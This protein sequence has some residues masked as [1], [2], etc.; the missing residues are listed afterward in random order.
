MLL[1]SSFGEADEDSSCRTGRRHRLR[2]DRRLALQV[3]DSSYEPLAQ[4]E[5]PVV[6]L[7]VADL[8]CPLLGFY[9]LH[10]GRT[11]FLVDGDLEHRHGS[12]SR[13]RFGGEP[14]ELRV[15]GEE[16]Y[17]RSLAAR[18]RGEVQLLEH[19]DARFL[20]GLAHLL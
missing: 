3:L 14:H 11:V 19:L 6:D 15:H 16:Q 9:G 2:S 18:A 10:T 12:G 17:V 20:Q 1:Y 13:V 5:A 4:F 7:G 8:A